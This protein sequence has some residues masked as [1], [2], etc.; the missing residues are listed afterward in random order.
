M[1]IVRGRKGHDCLSGL[2]TGGLGVPAGAIIER[3][4]FFQNDLLFRLVNGG[5]PSLGGFFQNIPLELIHKRRLPILQ[6]TQPSRR[7]HVALAVQT[8]AVL[9]REPGHRA[10][11]D[12][13]PLFI[14]QISGGQ[15]VAGAVVQQADLQLAVLGV[16]I[17]QEVM[18]ALWGV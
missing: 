14:A 9:I 7:G 1:L 18:L 4:G 3:D 16:Q 12:Q 10:Q 11:A 8:A 17:G 6:K 13:M 2:R 5:I 15:I